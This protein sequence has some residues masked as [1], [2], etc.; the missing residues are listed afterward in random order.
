MRILKTKSFAKDAKSQGLNDLALIKA[1]K[2]VQAGLV[3]ADLGGSLVKKRIAVGS[4]GKSGG[5]R[6]ILVYEASAENIFCLH[7]LQKTRL[8]IFQGN[9][10][11][12]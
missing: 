6:A 11:A 3:D 8:K 4:K 9:N 2:E 12:S 10:S 7:V 5:L 1:I